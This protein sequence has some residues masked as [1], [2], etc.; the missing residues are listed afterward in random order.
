MIFLI[1]GKMY[2]GKIKN[3]INLFL[4]EHE[5]VLFGLDFDCSFNK[6]FFRKLFLETCSYI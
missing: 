6:C 5:L 1:N 3:C 2:Y 4:V